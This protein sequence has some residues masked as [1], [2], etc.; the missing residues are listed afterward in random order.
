MISSLYNSLYRHFNIY[1]AVCEEVFNY[2]LEK[3]IDIFLCGLFRR[4]RCMCDTLLSN[5]RQKGGS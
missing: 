5:E 1:I 3:N 2:F 4:S